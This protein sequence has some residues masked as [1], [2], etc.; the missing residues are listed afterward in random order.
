MIRACILDG[1]L[2]AG[3]FCGGPRYI[4]R[5][6]EI[7][8]IEVAVMRLLVIESKDAFSWSALVLQHLITS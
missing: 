5:L 3:F 8:Q 6:I 4:L 2:R 7:S 1:G